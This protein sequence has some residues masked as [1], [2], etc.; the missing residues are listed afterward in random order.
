M[1]RQ[2]H[3]LAALLMA[4]TAALLTATMSYAADPEAGAGNPGALD[5]AIH[6]Y[7]MK[8]PKLI[9][10]ALQKAEE[11]DR[12]DQNK[13]LLKEHS[14]RLY[15]AGSPTL[16][17]AD[18]KITIVE[19]Y[20]YNCPYCRKAHPEL[21]AFLARN[22]DTRIILKDVATFGK[23][24]EAVARIALA[25]AR[26]GKLAEL[27]A[28]LMTSKGKASEATGL[29]LARKLGLDIDRLKKDAQ[30]AETASQLAETRQ[31]ADT[32]GVAVTP[33]FIIGH[34]GIPGAPDDLMAQIETFVGEVRSKG[35]EVC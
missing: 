35:C 26:Q 19:F 2:R 29:E 7:I 24:S 31:L 6:D 10:E 12:L 28:A 14:D 27:H 13:R 17:P 33:V 18:A 11:E 32:L 22:P 9:R 8:H 23:D 4:A 34:N 16:G 3:R 5:K 21:M 25:A 1:G 15:R 20:D 30:S